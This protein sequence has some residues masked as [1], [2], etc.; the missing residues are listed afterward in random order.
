MTYLP[1]RRSCKTRMFVHTMWS[2]FREKQASLFPMTPTSPECGSYA[3]NIMFS[4]YVSLLLPTICHIGC[5][6]FSCSV[7]FMQICDEIQTGL[8]RTGRML[9]TDHYGIRSDVVVLGK[10]LSGGMLPVSGVLT[11]DEVMMTIG[12]GEHGSTYGGNPLACAVA[13]EALQI[14]VDESLCENAQ[15]KGE[16]FRDAMQEQQQRYGWIKDVRGKGLLNAVELKRDFKYSGKDVC[17]ALMQ[18]GLLAKQ[19]HESIIRFAPPLV[20]NDSQMEEGIETIKNVFSG[21]D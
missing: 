4:W 11:R 10:A 7:Q 20:I 2:L 3:T 21:L 6:C 9:C 8:G 1:L 12:P 18:K 17:V 15:K 14:I 13:R 19:T 5:T 16:I